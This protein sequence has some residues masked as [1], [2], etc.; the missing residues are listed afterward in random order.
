M[1]G[2]PAAIARGVADD[3]RLRRLQILAEPAAAVERAAR[4]ARAGRATPATRHEDDLLDAEI[5]ELVEQADQA[6]GPVAQPVRFA[7]PVRI[8]RR[9]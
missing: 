1:R 6:V 3:R 7:A 8:G 5:D 4:A 2:R 9:T